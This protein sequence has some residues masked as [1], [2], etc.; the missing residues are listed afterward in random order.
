M[1]WKRSVFFAVCVLVAVSVTAGDIQTDGRIIST[2]GSGAPLEVASSEKVTNLN[3]DQLDGMDSAAFATVAA[4]VNEIALLQ[5]QLDQATAM[6]G[7]SQ[8]TVFVTSK[9]YSSALGGIEGAIIKC[10]ERARAAGLIGYYRPWLATTTGE[11]P[12]ALMNKA[13]VPYV[14]T[15]G[16]VVANDWA[17]LIDGTLTNLI[18]HDEFGEDLSATD[19]FASAVWSNVKLDGTTLMPSPDLSCEN[20]TVSTFDI[21]VAKGM[22]GL[23]VH[24]EVGFW[25]ASQVN[26]P[27]GFDFAPCA[28]AR[29]YCFQQ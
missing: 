2:A 4:L 1:L 13:T 23:F 25:T 10:N 18:D 17:D 22:V 21:N 5:A 9:T 26:D 14:R 3:A 20:W 7:I 15:D 29:L 28:L 12:A 27:P 8:K 11:N 6:L 24:S 16:A 19:V